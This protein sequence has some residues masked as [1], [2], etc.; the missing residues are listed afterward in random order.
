MKISQEDASALEGRKFDNRFVE[1]RVNGALIQCMNTDSA[2][3]ADYLNFVV[4]ILIWKFF[5]ESLNN[6]MPDIFFSKTTTGI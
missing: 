1:L 2:V 6:S 4:V 5:S 3:A